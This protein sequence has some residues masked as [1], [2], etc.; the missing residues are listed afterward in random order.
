MPS[1]GKRKFSYTKAG[2]KKAKA[3]AKKKWKKTKI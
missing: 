1:V 3:F 2:M